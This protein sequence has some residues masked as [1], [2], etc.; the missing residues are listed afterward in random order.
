AQLAP[1]P[2]AGRDTEPV[3]AAAGLAR[4]QDGT[5]RTP[6]ERLRAPQSGAGVDR[7][8]ESVL[9]ESAVE[10]G[11]AY[12]ESGRHRRAVSLYE[13]VLGE[14][15]DQVERAGDLPG[16]AGS[17]G[18]DGIV[19]LAVR[20]RVQDLALDL[21]DEQAAERL[22]REARRGARWRRRR[23]RRRCVPRR[24]GA[25]TPRSASARPRGARCRAVERRRQPRPAR[26]RSTRR[27]R[28]RTSSRGAAT[29]QRPGR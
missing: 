9:R 27:S 10:K 20:L 8:P 3:L 7:E 6:E 5:G 2:G 1:Q 25:R 15:E 18:R 14:V 22:G 26:H 24:A 17:E 12:L 11:G 29:R 28:W 4:R 21:R 23:A 16:G 13:V 19:R